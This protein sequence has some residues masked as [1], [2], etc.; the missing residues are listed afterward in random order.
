MLKRQQ[1]YYVLLPHVCLA[2]QMRSA[3]KLHPSPT[4]QWSACECVHRESAYQQTAAHRLQH[5]TTDQI[6]ESL[7]VMK[8]S[9]NLTTISC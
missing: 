3:V 8:T 4:L 6:T 1:Q 7:T 9:Q 5:S 2:T